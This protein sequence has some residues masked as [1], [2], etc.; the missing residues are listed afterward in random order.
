MNFSKRTLLD[1]RGIDPLLPVLNDD[2]KQQKQQTVKETTLPVSVFAIQNGGQ[3]EP[4]AYKMSS[5]SRTKCSQNLFFPPS[6]IPLI[7]D[8]QFLSTE[9]VNVF[10]SLAEV[11]NTFT[12]HFP[13]FHTVNVFALA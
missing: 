12:D 3:E 5:L 11:T 4:L 2:V 6:S 1:P 10:V 8:H 7:I 9:S 13:P